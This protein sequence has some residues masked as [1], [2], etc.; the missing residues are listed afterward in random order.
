MPEQIGTKKTA[1]C[2]NCDG[3]GCTDCGGTGK[4]EVTVVRQG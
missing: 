4:V 2:P 3:G 1:I